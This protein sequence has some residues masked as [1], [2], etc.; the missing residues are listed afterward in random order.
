MNRRWRSWLPPFVWAAILFAFS[1]GP[2]PEIPL[3]M[4]HVDKLEHAGA[5]SV[6]GFLVARALGG[7]VIAATAICGAYGVTD[8]IHQSF[9]PRRQPDALDAVADT[10]GGLIGASAWTLLRRRRG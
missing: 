1:S 10:A 5:Y 6:L 2:G 7:H 8:E 9:V 4:R 3:P